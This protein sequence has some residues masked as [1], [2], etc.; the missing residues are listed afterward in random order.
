M[1]R[2]VVVLFVH[3]INTT[4]REYYKP[5]LDR[6]V[7]RLPLSHQRCVVPRPV[8]WGNV[9]RGR[10]DE[11][12]FDAVKAGNFK[13]HKI[14]QLAIGGLGDAAAYTKTEQIK[15]SAY[16][17]IQ[18]AFRS[19]LADVALEP[20]D[21]RPLV[22]IA[23]SL[24]CHIT[25]TYAW[26]LHKYKHMGQSLR[27]NPDKKLNVDDDTMKFIKSLDDKTALERLDTFAGFVT[28]GCNMPLFTF[29]FGQHSV[30][31]ITHAHAP[32][33]HPPF[34]GEKLEPTVKAAARWRNYY[35]LNDPLGYPLKPLN[36][37]YAD[38]WYLSDHPVVS[39]NTIRQSLY[40][41][42]LRPLAAE[43]AHGNYWWSKD[44][45]A[46]AADLIKNIMDAPQPDYMHMFPNLTPTP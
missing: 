29:T 45:A 26:D 3:G 38:D 14:H 4:N 8:F 9:V 39:E 24:G 34:P 12:L 25:S 16:Y 30:T 28:M 27:A 13:P 35:S 11:Y 18:A 31:P 20:N 22:I 23:H 32:D 33:Y 44:V 36:D 5:L 19:A 10:T 1:P 21:E 15:M 43:A 6:I 2:D 17:R 37:K 7:E 46:G 40:Q 42:W 41:G